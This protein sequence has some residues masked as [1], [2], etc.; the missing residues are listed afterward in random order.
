MCKEDM[1][2]MELE[3]GVPLE[4]FV[5]QV[6]GHCSMMKF[7]EHTICKPLISRERYFY[8]SLPNDIRRFTPQYRGLVQVTFEESQDGSLNILAYPAHKKV[9][10]V[11]GNSSGSGGEGAESSEDSD[12]PQSNPKRRSKRRDEHSK[13]SRNRVRLL[14]SGSMDMSKAC[15]NYFEDQSEN[16]HRSDAHNPWS[17]HC[18]KIEV[19]KMR[20]N[21]ANNTLYKFILLENVASKF[22]YPCVLDLKMGTRVHGD[23][24]SEEKRERQMA[25]CLATTSSTLGIRVCGMQV[26]RL[27][28]GRFHCRNKYHGRR[29]SAEGVKQALLEFLYSGIQVRRDVISAIIER[30]IELKNILENKHSF[31]FYSSSLLIMYD[32][33]DGQYLS[34]DGDWL[35]EVGPKLDV[36]MIDFAHSTHKGFRGD[37]N[38]HSGPDTGY[39]YGLENLIRLFQEIEDEHS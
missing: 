23:D 30:L 24:A 13:K 8:E 4:P 35:G 5:H 20:N 12:S 14:H 3:G 32:G 39:L 7:D 19:A 16:L 15:D 10:D 2:R 18:H 21:S 31:R 1:D 37:N 36:R 25:K 38:I 29:L 9:K 26:Y 22:V 34:S 28:S 33:Q 27:N 11:S 17:L 6:G